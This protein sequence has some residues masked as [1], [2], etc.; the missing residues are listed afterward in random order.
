M[1]KKDEKQDIAESGE[2][3]LIRVAVRRIL[4]L[5]RKEGLRSLLWH[6]LPRLFRVLS[7]LVA[8]VVVAR[9][10]GA[11]DFGTLSFYTSAVMTTSSLVGLGALEVLTRAVATEPQHGVFTLRVI[12]RLRTWGAA[13]AVLIFIA[14][15]LVFLRPDLVLILAAV[16]LLLIPDAIEAYFFGEKKFHRTARL[17]VCAALLG[18]IARLSLAWTQAGL[19]AFAA[20][21][22][23]ETGIV[24]AGLLFMSPTRRQASRP[25]TPTDLG[26]YYKQ[27]FPLAITALVLAFS[28]RIDQFTLAWLR[29]GAE[30]GNYYAVLRFFEF[31][32]M[33]FPSITAA[34]LPRLALLYEVDREKFGTEM[35]KIYR[36]CYVG[37]LVSAGFL[38]LISPW[39]VGLVFGKEYEGASPI[40]R[41]YAFCLVFTLVGSIRAMH[42]IIIKNTMAHLWTCLAFLPL[43]PFSVYLPAKI[44]GAPGLA[45]AMIFNFAWGATIFS[46]ILPSCRQDW[47]YQREAL[48]LLFGAR[49]PA[50]IVA[51]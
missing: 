28:M 30:L 10:L 39:L 38:S 6:A 32:V 46:R 21:T 35:V 7:G 1:A 3:S 26:I 23:L 18:L 8:S 24:A 14:G 25:L 27:G 40:F 4:A 48:I 44:F 47:A 42:L 33:I 34:L 12:L 37:G 15:G 41:I 43:A 13:L 20:V 50:K 5:S 22:V 16:P 45:A 51:D 19:P 49:S 31:I 36:Y 11:E 29:P 17:R 2:E 9:H